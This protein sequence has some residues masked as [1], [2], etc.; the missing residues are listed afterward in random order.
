MKLEIKING[1]PHSAFGSTSTA[2]TWWTLIRWALNS[3]D[4][5]ATV[6]TATLTSGWTSH[7]RV[8]DVVRALLSELRHTGAQAAT[9]D[10]Q[11]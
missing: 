7:G 6:V 3:L 10:F 8:T 1:I 5:R 9:I 11:Q 2:T 4:F